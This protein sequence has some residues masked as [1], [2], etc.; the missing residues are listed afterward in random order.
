MFWINL[1]R[2]MNI[3]LI[4]ISNRMDVRLES[5]KNN[6][7]RLNIYHE[8][9]IYL[10]RLDKNDKKHVRREEVFKG[11][12]RIA[13]YG[14][15]DIIMYI[16]DAMGDFPEIESNNKFILPNPMYGKW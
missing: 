4:F 13:P 6:M 14:P 3:Q 10:L 15:F 5:T 8:N 1:V 7:K 2:E 12:G 11:S 9:D 16:G